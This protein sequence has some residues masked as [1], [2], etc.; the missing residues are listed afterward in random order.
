VKGQ[1]G[2]IATESIHITQLIGLG[3]VKLL[4][5]CSLH[6]YILAQWFSMYGLQPFGPLKDTFTGIAY[7]IF[8][9]SYIYIVIH[10]SSKVTVMK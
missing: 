10:N 8:V 7:Q 4:I 3:E 1:Q 5:T 9:L 6:T 2:L